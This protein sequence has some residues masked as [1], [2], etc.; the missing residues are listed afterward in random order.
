MAAPMLFEETLSFFS[1]NGTCEV[2]E[3]APPGQ[4]AVLPARNIRTDQ[5]WDV[6]FKWNATGGLTNVMAGTWK[7]GILLEKY[8]AEEAGLPPEYATTLVKFE[9]KPFSYDKIVHIPAGKVKPGVYKIVATI[10]MVGPLGEPGPM[11]GFGEGDLLQFYD[12]GA[13]S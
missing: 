3:H 4:Q 7:L 11:A 10:T 1:L 8:G 12:G 13:I 2:F 9:S 6:R 5:A